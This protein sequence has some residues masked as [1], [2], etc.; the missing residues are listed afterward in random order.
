MKT[1]LEEWMRYRKLTSETLSTKSGIAQKMI[2]KYV[3]G[4]TTPSLEV[5]SILAKNLEVTIDRLVFENPDETVE[6]HCIETP[7][8]K[9]AIK[10]QNYF[11]E[12][13][14]EVKVAVFP[15]EDESFIIVYRS[16]HIY[17]IKEVKKIISKLRWL[18]NRYKSLNIEDRYKGM[19][20]SQR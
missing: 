5:A 2:D 19:I 14:I 11:E 18:D 10:L 15:E 6:T 4:V 13:G 9:E 17:T 7:S 16:S 1:R 20:I 3:S 12:N 8:I